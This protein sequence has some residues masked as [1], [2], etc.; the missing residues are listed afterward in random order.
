MNLGDSMKQP[1]TCL[2]MLFFATVFT[3]AQ[4]PPKPALQRSISEL[5]AKIY[6]LSPLERRKFYNELDGKM[7]AKL[8]LLHIASFEIDHNDSLNSEQADFIQMLKGILKGADLD[9]ERE[10]IIARLSGQHERAITLFGR[11]DARRILSG[12]GDPD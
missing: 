6:S 1:I 12:L 5:C 3:V 2:A 9:A 11:S 7:K 10:I 8:W 4:D